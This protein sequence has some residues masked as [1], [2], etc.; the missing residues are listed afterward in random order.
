MRDLLV[1]RPTSR[2]CAICS[3]KPPTGIGCLV[4][5]SGQPLAH[6]STA[7]TLT[8]IAPK[9]HQWPDRAPTPSGHFCVPQTALAA[10]RTHRYHTQD[11][12]AVRPDHSDR[13]KPP[14]ANV[15]A[16]CIAA[17][18]VASRLSSAY[19]FRWSLSVTTIVQ[20]ALAAISGCP[21]DRPPRVHLRRSPHPQRASEPAI[22]PPTSGTAR[23]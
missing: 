14:Q 21:G 15:A 18:R 1:W 10:Y 11:R 12:L 22:P 8:R 13:I 9:T 4:G 23:T 16:A 5:L 3:S 7:S 20:R 6:R 17:S 2:A 19:G